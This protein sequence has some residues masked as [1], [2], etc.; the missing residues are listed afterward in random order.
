MANGRCRVLAVGFDAPITKGVCFVSMPASKTH[1]IQV[2]GRC[3][4]KHPNKRMASVVLPFVTGHDDGQRA[5]DFFRILAQNDKRL[6]RALVCDGLGYVDVWTPTGGGVGARP[7]LLREEIADSVHRAARCKLDEMIEAV[8][9][10]HQEHH[11]LPKGNDTI[12]GR[13]TVNQQS[14]R[15]KMSDERKKALL[16]LPFWTWRVSESAEAKWDR[17]C[18]TLASHVQTHGAMPTTVN[19]KKLYVW[20]YKQ[21]LR[22]DQL[23]DAQISKLE[24]IRSDY[25][26]PRS[27]STGPVLSPRHISTIGELFQTGGTKPGLFPLSWL[28]KST[29]RSR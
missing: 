11:A 8:R 16:A 25:F 21:S 5:C 14:S 18:T 28:S 29:A 23:S 19:N 7:L 15:D 13:W 22:R 26:K 12:L 24:A 6:K 10:Y 9:A 27:V 3:L 2:V 1:I 4:R 17:M 20:A